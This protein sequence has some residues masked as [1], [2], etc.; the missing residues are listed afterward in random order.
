MTLLRN[1]TVN[2]WFSVADVL[3]SCEYVNR[4]SPTDRRA[5]HESTRTKLDSTLAS[6][7]LVDRPYCRNR[8]D[9]RIHMKTEFYRGKRRRRD[10]PQNSYGASE[11]PGRT[12]AINISSLRNCAWLTFRTDQEVCEA[13]SQ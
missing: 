7:D 4:I 11:Q 6:C 9:P 2:Q 1:L 5:I 12:R 8:K 13:G 3:I 10:G